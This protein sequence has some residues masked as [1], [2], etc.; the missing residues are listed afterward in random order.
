MKQGNSGSLCRRQCADRTVQALNVVSRFDVRLYDP[1]LRLCLDS[2]RQFAS[3][4]L[5][6]GIAGA[7]SGDDPISPGGK[8]PLILQSIKT[9]SDLQPAGLHGVAS[10]IGIARQ[11][12]CVGDEAPLPASH[13]VAE[14]ATVTGT[15]GYD[16]ILV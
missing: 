15:R 3:A 1:G 7:T 13:Q 16:E 5:P 2:A 11:S 12:P 8:R 4:D 9:A 10:C 6:S 14:C